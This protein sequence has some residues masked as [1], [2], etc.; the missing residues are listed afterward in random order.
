MLKKVVLFLVFLLSANPAFA[1]TNNSPVGTWLTI[2]DNTRKPTALIQII[3]DKEG[4]L[5]AKALKGLRSGDSPE[6]RCTEC[7]DERKN[8]KIQGMTIMKNMKPNGDEWNGGKILDPDIGTEY[9]CKMHLE[10]GGRK[11]VVRGFIGFS[12]LGRSQV[13]IRQGN[14][15]E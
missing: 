14:N 8:Q 13:W 5:S 9:S 12:L 2:D 10:D 3:Q 11:L 4:I 6:R 7:T 15:N 1:D